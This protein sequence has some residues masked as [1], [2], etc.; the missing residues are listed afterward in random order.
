MFR[1]NIENGVTRAERLRVGYT[2]RHL[3]MAEEETRGRVEEGSYQEFGKNG[4]ISDIFIS[5]RKRYETPNT[6]AFIK[7]QSFGGATKAVNR[8]NGSKWNKQKIYVRLSNDINRREQRGQLPYDR[9]KKAM[10]KWVEIGRKQ[11]KAPGEV[12][13]FNK[14]GTLDSKTVR[15]KTVEATWSEEQKERLDRS[16]LGVSSKPIDFRIRDEALENQLLLSLFDE[17]RYH[18]G[19]FW[20]LSRRVWLEVNGMPIPLWCR[21]NFESIAKLWGK[22]IEYDDRGDESKSYSIA[23]VLVDCYEWTMINEWINLKVDDKEFEVYVKEVGAEVYS[24]ESHPNLIDDQLVSLANLQSQSV[25]EETPTVSEQRPENSKGPILNCDNMESALINAIIDGKL[26]DGHTVSCEIDYGIDGVAQSRTN[27]RW[28]VQ[29][30]GG[31]YAGGLNVYP[32]VVVF[33]QPDLDPMYWEAQLPTCQ[34]YY[35]RIGLPKTTKRPFVDEYSCNSESNN[36]FPFPPGFGQ[37]V[38]QI[39]LHR[40]E[41]R[42]GNH[43]GRVEGAT[44]IET[45]G[46]KS[47]TLNVPETSKTAGA[48]AGLDLVLKNVVPIDGCYATRSKEAVDCGKDA[49]SDRRNCCL[50]EGDAKGSND[51][52]EETTCEEIQSSET[53]YRSNPDV[54]YRLGNVSDAAEGPEV[55]SGDEAENELRVHGQ[56]GLIVDDVGGVLRPSSSGAPCTVDRA[57]THC[58]NGDILE[59]SA[60]LSDETLYLI[61]NKFVNE[62]RRAER[63]SS[64]FESEGVVGEEWESI[65][66]EDNS[67][68]ILAA[69]EVWC[70]AGLFIGSSEEEEIHSKIV[71]QKKVEGKRRPDLRPKE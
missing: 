45:V 13:G 67:T 30:V 42:D 65:E 4:Y 32:N 1:E 41:I 69:K 49:K 46:E 20:S 61:N 19:V 17:V 8:M 24:V 12:Q 26:N 56:E 66:E 70:H 57:C 7:F 27:G 44:L 35:D 11:D 40:Q 47:V 22:V 38:G 31:L 36:S 52:I 5:R 54:L 55:W 2:V 37:C 9:Y 53:L 68:E 23:R 59:N 34:L 6:F 51:S 25:V 15:R 48:D 71:R 43:T 18:W 62:P 14:S 10:K 58:V 64:E 63:V 60:S 3:A 29:Q 33:G 28:N 21:E 16:L 50:N 39:H